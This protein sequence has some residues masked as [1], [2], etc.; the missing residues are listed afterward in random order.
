MTTSIKLYSATTVALQ[1]VWT[2]LLSLAGVALMI[3]A[4]ILI[5][6][7][8]GTLTRVNQLVDDIAPSVRS[9]L[10]KMP[11]TMENVKI[12]SGNMV[13]LTDDLA[14]QVPDIMGDAKEM[15][16]S[17]KGAVSSVSETVT[18]A[19]DLVSGV[20]GFFHRPRSTVEAVGDVLN[21]ARR[22]TK[23]VRRGARKMR[24]KAGR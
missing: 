22:A 8:I 11:A 5:V 2:T 13:D 19:S 6:K 9:S 10:E 3:A 17:L 15:T 24:R 14:T 23:F 21:T 16:G 18:D 7:L 20:V 4:I 12:I 1:D